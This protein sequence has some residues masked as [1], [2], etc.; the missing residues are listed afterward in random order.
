[1]GKHFRVWEIAWICKQ[2]LDS[3]LKSKKNERQTTSKKN[4]SEVLLFRNLSYQFLKLWDIQSWFIY[5]RIL[6]V[7]FTQNYVSFMN[8]SRN[9]LCFCN[10]PRSFKYTYSFYNLKNWDSWKN[11][12]Y[13]KV[14]FQKMKILKNFNFKFFLCCWTS[15]FHLFKIEFFSKYI[16]F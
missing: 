9:L 5:C 15:R 12:W 13:L 6:D 3:K 16:R 8:L 4:N 7:W 2:Y 14:K 10:P 1:M 11:D